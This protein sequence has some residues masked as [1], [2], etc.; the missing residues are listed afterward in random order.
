MRDAPDLDVVFGGDRDLDV[1][2]EVAVAAA[3]L[4]LIGREDDVVALRPARVRVV[5]R[6][7]DLAAFRVAHVE[8]G[9]PAVARDVLAVACHR[10]AVPARVPAT[11]VRHHDRVAAVG[12]EVRRGNGR[13]GGGVRARDRRWQLAHRAHVLDLLGVRRDELYVARQ[14]SCSSSSAEPTI[15]SSW[16]RSRIRPSQ[17]ALPSAR[18]AMPWWCAK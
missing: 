10:D 13:I 18:N 17:S 11:A 3:E 16:N 5:R 15:G 12:Q 14:R 6:R 7:E 4:G 9:A 1:G 8:E 2:L